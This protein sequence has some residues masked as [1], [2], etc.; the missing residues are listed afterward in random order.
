MISTG[1][2]KVAPA[3]VEEVLARHDDVQEVGVVPGPCPT[4]L[5]MVVAYVVLR[6]GVEGSPELATAL[7]EYVKTYLVSYKAP[8]RIEFVASLPRDA[9][10]KVQTKIIKQWAAESP[11]VRVRSTAVEQS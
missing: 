7:R 11:G 1:G 10:G 4:N 9:V 2:Y 6:H 8:R 3:E 5:E